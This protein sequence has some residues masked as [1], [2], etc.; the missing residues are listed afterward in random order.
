MTSERDAFGESRRNGKASHTNGSRETASFPF[1]AGD[2][3]VRWFAEC[4]DA[5]KHAAV[6][7]LIAVA[8]GDGV[9]KPEEKTA[10]A[11]A[12]ER[13]GVSSLDVAAAL[14]R[15]MPAQVDPPADPRA[16]IQL[17]LDCA[18]V[19]V[20]D[21]RIDDRELAVLLMVGRSLG[22]TAAQVGE[23][24]SHVAQALAAEQRR[25]H[26]I[27]RLLDEMG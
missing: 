8:T 11:S 25:Q 2:P 19:M 6:H 22:F 7:A 5:Q 15:H 24:A 26:L 18:A 27:E 16:R 12:C 9:L 20:A 10:I 21:N 4:T 23:F 13:L 14:A 3:R 1:P 17:V